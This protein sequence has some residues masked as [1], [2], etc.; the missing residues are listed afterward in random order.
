[1]WLPILFVQNASGENS[2]IFNPD[3]AYQ[4]EGLCMGSFTGIS[5]I[6]QQHTEI[7]NIWYTCISVPFIFVV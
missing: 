4:T 2:V 5:E 1:M 3:V 7:V 6:L